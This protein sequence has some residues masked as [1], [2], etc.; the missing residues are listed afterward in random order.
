MD[1][2]G[3]RD[4]PR[5]PHDLR[6]SRHPRDAVGRQDS[7][8]A[9]PR[10]P[11][12]HHRGRADP[13]SSSRDPCRARDPRLLH[14]AR[15][16]RGVRVRAVHSR[17]SAPRRPR[18]GH[19][20]RARAQRIGIGSAGLVPAA[21]GLRE[22][23]RDPRRVW[24]RR[25]GLSADPVVPHPCDTSSPP[26]HAPRRRR[27]SRALSPVRCTSCLH[28]GMSD[29]LFLACVAAAYQLRS[30]T[31]GGTLP[32]PT[33][34]PPG[35]PSARWLVVTGRRRRA[36]S[37]PSPGSSRRRADRGR[38]PF[39]RVRRPHLSRSR[40]E[41]AHA[42]R[43]RRGDAAVPHRAIRQPFGRSSRRL[44][45]ARQALD[46]AREV[47]AG[48]LGVDSGEIVFTGDGTEAD[49]T[50]IFGVHAAREGSVACS[51]VEHHAVLH[52]VEHLQGRCAPR[53]LE[54][55]RRPRSAGRRAGLDG[56]A[57]V[58]HGRQQ[59]GRHHPAAVG[60]RR[61]RRRAG[62]ERRPAQRCH[63]GVRLAG[64]RRDVRERPS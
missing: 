1:R 28:P 20:R 19:R 31:I 56:L 61:G 12:G 8:Q 57:G 40:G 29:E 21:L 36:R 3:H 35:M 7:R 27:D 24:P 16:A 51:A 45:A 43:G 55:R 26:G 37:P 14:P 38:L 9:R 33:M 48:C 39:R 63:P 4:V 59:R 54:R 18:R 41:H 23:H 25:R 49:N 46:E 17:R 62:A 2:R 13:L 34:A 22:L 60:R 58:G 10:H 42:A 50:A 53:R 52:P 15:R 32:P 5:L 64:R 47:V 30:R 11:G 6:I 44:R